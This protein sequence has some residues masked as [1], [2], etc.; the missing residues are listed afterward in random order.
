MA[1]CVFGDLS[2][3]C[4]VNLRNLPQWISV[5]RQ[6]R[7]C[8]DARDFGAAWLGFDIG[9]DL[10]LKHA[11]HALNREHLRCPLILAFESED[12]IGGIGRLGANVSVVIGNS[13]L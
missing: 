13:N 10:H 2:T 6:W 12:I 4:P 3:L 5:F 8:R 9:H 7:V 11:R 1:H